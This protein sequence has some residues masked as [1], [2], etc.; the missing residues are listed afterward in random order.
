MD[1]R[2]KKWL[3]KLLSNSYQLLHSSRLWGSFHPVLGSPALTAA[4]RAAF[5]QGRGE[6]RWTRLSLVSDNRFNATMFTINTKPTELAFFQRILKPALVPKK[7]WVCKVKPS[8][9]STLAKTNTSPFPD[10]ILKL[11]L[12]FVNI[13]AFWKSKFKQHGEKASAIKIKLKT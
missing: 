10:E 5:A 8:L 11:Y 3:H 1:G 4:H 12:T 7:S 9:L 2:K 13:L 6:Q